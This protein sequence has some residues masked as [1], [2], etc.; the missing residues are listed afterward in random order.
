MNRP[1]YAEIFE[2]VNID[3]AL[4][5][6]VIRNS[7]SAKIVKGIK[8][9]TG[10]TDVFAYSFP[11]TLWEYPYFGIDK[12]HGSLTQIFSDIGYDL[13]SHN[14][15]FYIFYYRDEYYHFGLA[16]Y[17]GQEKD[18]YSGRK[19]EKVSWHNIYGVPVNKKVTDNSLIITDNFSFLY[20]PH[21]EKLD[22]L[23]KCTVIADRKVDISSM[24]KIKKIMNKAEFC[25]SND[26]ILAV[27]ELPD[28]SFPQYIIMVNEGGG[29]FDK[30]THIRYFR[31]LNDFDVVYDYRNK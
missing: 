28:D 26:G 6:I 1:K 20:L 4:P 3:P 21:I 12:E 16:T 9:L 18:K 25:W 15:K 5:I 14:N 22:P 31:S 8:Q 19:L 10:K 24:Y 30:L 29:S 11:R 2:V 13:T 27:E 17:S 7:E 23:A